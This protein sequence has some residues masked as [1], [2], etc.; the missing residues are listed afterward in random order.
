MKKQKAKKEKAQKGKKDKTETT[1]TPGEDALA[2]K[3]EVPTEDGALDADQPK[4]QEPLDETVSA[5][6]TSEDPLVSAAATT[7]TDEP[8]STEDEPSKPTLDRQ[9]TESQQSRLR[10]ESFK[11]GGEEVYKKQAA[12]IEQLE[13]ENTQ[14]VKEAEAKVE[15]IRQAEAQIEELREGQSEVAELR[16][17]ASKVD[18]SNNEVERLVSPI[19]EVAQKIEDEWTDQDAQKS[20]IQSLERQNAQLQS[21]DKRRRASS[22]AVPT[23]SSTTSHDEQLAAKTSTIESLELEISNLRHSITTLETDNLRLTAQVKDLETSNHTSTSA[24]HA[25]QTEL[26]TLRSAASTAT[27]SDSSNPT[28]N[29]N[30]DATRLRL[31]T[32]DLAAAQRTA[33]DASARSE[34]LQKKIDTLTSLHR[35]AETSRNKEV[36]KLRSETA[37]LRAKAKAA[38]DAPSESTDGE[39]D[40]DEGEGE[41]TKAGMRAKIRAL[42]SEVFDLKRGVWREKRMELQEGDGDDPMASVNA[43]DPA[44]GYGGAG[45]GYNPPVQSPGAR[46]IYDDV[47]LATPAQT[48]GYSQSPSL[49]RMKSSGLSAF[50][51]N[52]VLS[53]F[54]GATSPPTQGGPQR[55][56][57]PAHL[58]RKSSLG[59]GFF[60]AAA[61]LVGSVTGAGGDENALMEEGEDEDEFVFDEDAFRKAREEEDRKRLERVRG[62]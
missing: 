6:Q 44:Y 29:P 15:Q 46:S 39:D 43:F 11:S 19:E 20:E 5:G 21:A 50:S 40:E 4:A 48:G 30:D 35:D 57:P 9:L 23:T 45:G 38:I 56:G 32:T 36:D 25:A 22:V 51:V 28:T 62:S 8:P 61:D 37:A 3:E 14:L 13:K 55:G 7:I 34:T 42:E 18:G 54:T 16:T 52:N 49:N 24:L 41:N 47:D 17:K 2:E 26:T 60:A 12:R 1:D 31:L 59:G 58:R 33:T 53:A 27:L 10:S